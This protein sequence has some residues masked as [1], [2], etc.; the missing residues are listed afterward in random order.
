MTKLSISKAWE[1]TTL[2]I[3][4][5][6]RLLVP[7]ALAL[8]ALPAIV[9]GLAA[10]DVTNE[11]AARSPGLMVVIMAE[12]LIGAVGQLAIARLA[13]GHRERLGEA[14]RHGAARLPALIGGF[15]VV[16]VP[17]GA[18]LAIVAGSASVVTKG[19]AGAGNAAIALVLLV[20][21]TAL[22]VATLI[23]L[24]RCLLMLPLASVEAGGPI[25]LVR[26]SFAVSR[27]AVLRLLAAAVLF[28]VGGAVLLVAVRSV[29]GAVVIFG[30]G[31]PEAW[32][33]SALLIALVD[34]VVQALIGTVFTVFTARLYAQRSGEAGADTGLPSNAI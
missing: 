17:M 31:K 27:G 16:G 13:L 20:I 28:L 6:A 32:T 8:I 2:F 11:V 23:V 24:A 4:R 14:I 3:A 21:M 29:L 26:R 5:D 10:P 22:F 34:G 18:T 25:R 12:F 7:L 33:V 15:L 1:E 30:L 9:F 19:G